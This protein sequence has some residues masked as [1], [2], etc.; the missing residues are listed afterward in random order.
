MADAGEQAMEVDKQPAKDQQKAPAAR[1]Y[2]LPW[3]SIGFSCNT[4]Q[5]CNHVQIDDLLGFGML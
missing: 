2:E 5:A 4:L 3:V 1:T